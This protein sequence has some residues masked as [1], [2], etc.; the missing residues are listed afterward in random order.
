MPQYG[1]DPALGAVVSSFVIGACSI[2]RFML[3]SDM[4]IDKDAI[5]ASLQKENEYLKVQNWKRRVR[6]AL[7][8][9]H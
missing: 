1:L 5:I 6:S 9:R 4:G 3:I 7:A 2:L 8:E